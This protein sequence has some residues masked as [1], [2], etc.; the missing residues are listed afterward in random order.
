MRGPCPRTAVAEIAT[1]IERRA[2]D[3]EH[4]V[5]NRVA[6]GSTDIEL[7]VDIAPPVGPRVTDIELPAR[8]FTLEPSGSPK[9]YRV[10]P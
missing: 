7:P 8:P 1:D 6:S 10:L 3:I 5:E 2:T 4:R 9:L